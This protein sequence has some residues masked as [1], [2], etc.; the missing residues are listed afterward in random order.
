L[1]PIIAP[2]ALD[3]HELGLKRPL[4]AIEKAEHC[5]ALGIQT[6]PRIEFLR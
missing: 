5:R 2:P 4:S 1:R 6:Q 3:L